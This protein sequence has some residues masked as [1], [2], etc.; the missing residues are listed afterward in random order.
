M[1]KYFPTTGT[2]RLY[3]VF[4]LKKNSSPDYFFWCFLFLLALW[5]FFHFV[6]FS[7]SFSHIFFFSSFILFCGAFSVFLWQYGFLLQLH[8]Q[9]NSFF[10]GR[11]GSFFVILFGDFE[12]RFF[13]LYQLFYIVFY[14]HMQAEIELFHST[15]I[16]LNPIF[17]LGQMV[18]WIFLFFQSD[19]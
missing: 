15:V 12:S 16:I 7:I 17:C 18:T 14:I 3:Q 5:L 2:K 4:L 1:K 19:I 8:L 6:F 13:P 9:S 10:D 11:H